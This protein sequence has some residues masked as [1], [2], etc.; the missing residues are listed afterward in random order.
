MYY[1]VQLI[2]I[3]MIISFICNE[4]SILDIHL[5]LFKYKKIYQLRN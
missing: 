5:Y 1:A 4:K 2:S 3:Y